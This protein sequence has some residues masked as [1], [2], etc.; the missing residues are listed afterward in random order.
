MPKAPTKKKIVT[1]QRRGPTTGASASDFQLLRVPLQTMTT[2]KTYTFKRYYPSVTQTT[3]G[4]TELFAGYY[5]TLNG[6]DGYAEFTALFDQYRIVEIGVHATPGMN[7]ETLAAGGSGFNAQLL[8][9]VDFDDAS[10]P[11]S[12]GEMLQR[13]N[14]Q[15]WMWSK[16]FSFRYRPRVATAAYSGAFTSYANSSPWL[17]VASPAVQYYGWKLG[18]TPGVG[19]I[20]A[21]N[22]L[23]YAVVEF[24]SVR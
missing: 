6:L 15:S 20:Y 24:R 19:Q 7:T 16:P 17:D 12:Q 9:Y 5:H 23:T 13:Q 22:F 8:T 11:A 4:S 10:P 2:A 1:R 3:D 21:V 14:L 18:I